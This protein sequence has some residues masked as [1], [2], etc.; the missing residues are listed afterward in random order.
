MRHL[1]P[2]IIKEAFLGVLARKGFSFIR[3][4]PGKTALM[5]VGGAFNTMGTI[6]GAQKINQQAGIGR[7]LADFAANKAGQIT[8]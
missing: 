8:M 5:G 3:K 6:Q 2:E 1:N 4:N 7:N